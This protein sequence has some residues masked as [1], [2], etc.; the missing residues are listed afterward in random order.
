VTIDRSRESIKLI[1]VIAGEQKLYIMLVALPIVIGG[2]EK[3]KDFQK[4]MKS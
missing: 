2:K 1:N 4:A 3:K